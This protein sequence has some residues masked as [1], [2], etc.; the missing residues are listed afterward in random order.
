[1]SCPLLLPASSFLTITI[2]FIFSQNTRTRLSPNFATQST[3][4]LP[5]SIDSFVKRQLQQTQHYNLRPLLSTQSTGIWILSYYIAVEDNTQY[6]VHG[7]PL[8]A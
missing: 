8:K 6:Q 3:P 2:F 1:M 7:G 4:L 5:V